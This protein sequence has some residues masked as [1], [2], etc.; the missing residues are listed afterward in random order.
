MLLI[1]IHEKIELVYLCLVSH[2]V[3]IRGNWEMRMLDLM[4]SDRVRSE[5][6]I[7]LR[8][9]WKHKFI[10]IEDNLFIIRYRF[11]RRIMMIKLSHFYTNVIISLSMRLIVWLLSS[12]I[13]IYLSNRRVLHVLTLFHS[14][15]S[16]SVCYCFRYLCIRINNLHVFI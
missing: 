7:D 4:T 10:F 2:M 14:W 15:S 12:L 11:S 3:I 9:H 6:I 5:F 16:H 13:Q 8:R 1:V